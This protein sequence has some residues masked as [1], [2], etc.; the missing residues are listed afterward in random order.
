LMNTARN[1]G[2]KSAACW[3]A[4]MP[5]APAGPR[6]G[7]SSCGRRFPILRPEISSR[8]QVE[9]LLAGNFL[10]ADLAV[11]FAG[12]ARGLIAEIA[13]LFADAEMIRI[14]GDCHFANIIHRPGESFYLIDFD[15]MSLGPPV[16]DMWMLLPGHRE[17]SAAEIDFFLEGYETFRDFDR[18]SL[19]LIEPLRAMRFIHYTAWCAWQ[20]AEEGL[21][22]VAPDF[23]T[24]EYWQ[25]EINDLEEQRQR[26]REECGD[27]RW[28]Q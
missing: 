28:A 14:H 25:R 15:D 24:R 8:D 26:I 22:R 16:Q 17:D 5:W 11:L 13:P 1:S 20:V 7:G 27:G 21:S 2:W 3:A 12:Q 23:G 19:R 9:Y 10:P 6:K 4:S 18:R